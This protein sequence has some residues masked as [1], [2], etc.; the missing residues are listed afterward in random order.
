M[1]PRAYDIGIALG[2]V[3]CTA[4]AGLLA[5]WAWGLVVLGSLV[6]VTTVVGAFLTQPER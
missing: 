4:G 2:T 3:C 5:G 1:N 6:L